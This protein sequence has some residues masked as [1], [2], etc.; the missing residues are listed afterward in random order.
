MTISYL[1]LF[2][3][4]NNFD[5]SASG[6]CPIYLLPLRRAQRVRR[7]GCEVH[8]RQFERW[9]LLFHMGRVQHLYQSN[10]L[11]CVERGCCRQNAG[12]VSLC[13]GCTAFVDASPG[14]LNF[15]VMTNKNLKT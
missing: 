4:K 10:I 1:S 6:S 9:R 2:V 15:A 8:N 5:V 13:A 14:T 7:D 11:E 3:K 12:N